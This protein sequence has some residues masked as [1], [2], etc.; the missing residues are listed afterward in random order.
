MRMGTPPTQ[1]IRE[2]D[3]TLAALKRLPPNNRNP[4]WEDIV[5]LHELHAQHE[6]AHGRHDRALAAEER[7]RLVLRHETSP[8]LGAVR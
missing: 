7:A 4:K 5:H 8:P 1:R 3:E 2:A 6:H